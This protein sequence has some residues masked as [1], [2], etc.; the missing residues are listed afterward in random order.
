MATLEAAQ[1]RYRDPE[2]ALILNTIRAARQ[3]ETHLLTT[4]KFSSADIL[5]RLGEAFDGRTADLIELVMEYEERLTEFRAHW[6]SWRKLRR[7]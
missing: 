6:L 7:D 3:L 1:M 5:I 4:N 2:L